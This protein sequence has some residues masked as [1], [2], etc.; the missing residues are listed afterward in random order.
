MF[1][2]HENLLLTPYFGFFSFCGGFMRRN[3][4]R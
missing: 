2:P 3:E 1:G 4:S